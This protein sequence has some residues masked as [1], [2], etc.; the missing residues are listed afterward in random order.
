MV[1]ETPAHETPR[2]VVQAWQEAANGRDADRLIALSTPD[3]EIVG[4]RGS[5]RGHRVLRDW[6]ARAGVELRP[7]RLFARRDHVVVAQHGAWRA[8]GTG[9]VIGEQVV[10]SSFRVVDGRVARVARFDSLDVALADA[11]LGKVDEV[12]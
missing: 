10:A 12:A 4:P 5:A 1:H 9:E 8:A 2:D 7:L 3:I 6:L 11:G